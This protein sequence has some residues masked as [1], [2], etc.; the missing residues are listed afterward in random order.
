[1]T[2]RKPS[3]QKQKQE[4]ALKPTIDKKELKTILLI[5]AVGFLLRLIYVL[6][7]QS[8][9]FIQNLF[10]DSQIYFD[11][12]K[13]M[14]QSNNWFGKEAHFMSP[15]YTYFLALAIKFFSI[16]IL[17]IRV[18]QV[19][20]STAIVYFIYLLA[21]NLFDNRTA[22][23]AAAI[24]AVYSI[25]IFYSGAIFGETLQTLFV[26]AF[27]YFLT[28]NEEKRKKWFYAGLMLGLASLFRGNILLIFPAILI[29]IYLIYKK[30]KT[31]KDF[32]KKTL[33]FFSIGTVI[34]VLLITLNNYL[35]NKDFVLLSSNGGINFYL[36]NNENSLGVYTSPKDFDFFKDMAGINY[37]RKVTGKNLSPSEAS[38]YWFNEGINYISSHPGDAIL[39]TFKKLL[40][41]FDD[42]ENPQTS[43]I[44]INFFRDK[45]STLLKI[46][47]PNFI[48]VL[49]LAIIGIVF[50]V[51][52]SF[53]Q[54]IKLMLIILIVYIVSVV[55]FFVVGRFRIA[56]APL[57]ITFAAYGLLQLY[58]AIK[59]KNFAKTLVPVS[60]S[61]IVLVLVVFALPD[62]NYSYADA[63]SNLG[64]VYFDQK[65]IGEALKN[66]NESLKIKET[67]ITYVQIGNAFQFK[68][69]YVNSESAYR[70]ALRLNPNYA[71]AYFNL[72]SI[73]AQQRKFE[74]AIDLFSKAIE[75][76][77][78]LAEAYR[79]K[80][81]IYYMAEDF[82][83][84]LTNFQK[85]YS[86]ITD[87]NIKA[88][89]LHDI[90]DLKQKLNK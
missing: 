43:Q 5:I 74:A 71:L 40:L 16:S 34:P 72:G 49:M 47:L 54:K 59:N 66:Y 14:A 21:I 89:V 11:L 31:Q 69:D 1:M 75:I 56:I 26:T 33:L 19:I 36:G 12:A 10:S 86:L 20:V 77:P 38:F 62:Y 41:F 79:N 39:L 64:N 30:S 65:N 61:S 84:S 29:W 18:L 90:N 22:K 87:E 17:F 70:N 48:V 7:T 28:C 25:F 46:P 76:D 63:Y 81:V 51:S 67:A 15:G 53:N 52:S 45:Y 85:Y 60:T 27:L 37:A 68:K 57:L 13:N 73:N 42:S 78:A 80:A 2:K 88:T 50:S 4:K 6:E 82:Q 32:L 83:N 9:P 44:N 3:A 23:I 58:N 8:S 24:A 55:L 35:A